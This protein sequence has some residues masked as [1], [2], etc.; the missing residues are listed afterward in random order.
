MACDDFALFWAP[1][2][3]LFFSSPS[4]SQLDP[5]SSGGVLSNVSLPSS[6][7][8][9][10]LPMGAHHLNLMFEDPADPPDVKQVRAAQEPL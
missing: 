8:A 6:V 10:L 2:F 5:W 7:I 3:P 1:L 4:S 9:L